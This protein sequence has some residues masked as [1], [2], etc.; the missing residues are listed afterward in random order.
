MKVIISLLLALFLVACGDNKSSSS[1]AKEVLP[2]SNVKV[3]TTQQ[4]VSKVKDMASSA[5]DTTE[6]AFVKTK[7]VGVKVTKKIKE[8][9]ATNSSK[10]GATIFKSCAGCHGQ[11]A[12]KKAL[13]KSEIIAGWNSSKLQT[14]L[15][16]YKSGTRNKHGMGVIMKGQTSKLSESDIK[17]VS[18]YISKL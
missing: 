4:A 7:E 16:A 10:S 2:V 17:S 9:I 18:N 12:G 1:S 11:K 3:S 13:G 15:K 5:V 6:K 8:V 14:A